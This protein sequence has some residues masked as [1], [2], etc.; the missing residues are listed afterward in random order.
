MQVEVTAAQATGN[1][2]TSHTASDSCTAH[3]ALC[4]EIQDKG[5]AQ[6]SPPLASMWSC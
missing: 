4:P 6:T 1:G 3:T 2:H 5:K